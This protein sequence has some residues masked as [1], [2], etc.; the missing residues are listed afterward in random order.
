MTLKILAVDSANRRQVRQFLDLPFRI[1]RQD[2]Q[3]M[4]LWVPP[5]ETDARR[6][7][8]Q[9]RHPFYRDSQ[10]AFFMAYREGQPVGRIAVLNHYRYNEYN[11]ERTAFFYLFECFPDEEASHSLFQAACSW[12]AARQ[13]TKIIGPKGFTVLDGMGLLARGFEHRPALGQPYNPPYYLQLLEQEGFTP[14]SEV[15]SGYLDAR[16]TFPEKIHQ[17]SATVQQRR[18]LHIACYTRRRDLLP[19]IPKLKELYN[20]VLAGTSGNYPLTDDEVKTMANQILWFSDP[21]LIKVIHKGDEPVGFL[22]AYPDIS[23]ALQ[24]CKGRLF[25][26]GWIDCLRELRRTQWINLNGAGILPQYRGLGGTAILFSEMYKSVA[27]SRYRYAD[28]VQIG[29][30]ND[31]MLRELRGLGVE[32][33]KAHRVYQKVI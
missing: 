8:D 5:L 12:A 6:M 25:P 32:F 7:L 14:V 17:V 29:A 33:Y 1:Y 28:L 30:E 26:F 31:R 10:A 18:G 24:R 16:Q 21:R 9:R 2:A 4:S 22:L 23:A 19:L 3:W 15:V 27:E 11:R 13:L 20:G